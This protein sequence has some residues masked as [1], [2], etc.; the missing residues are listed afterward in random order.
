M[1]IQPEWV[2][3]RLE[4]RP[5]ALLITGPAGSGKSTLGAG[6]AVRTG[7]ALVDEDVLTNPLVAVVAELAGG[8]DDIDHAR[9]RERVR[10]ARYRALFD[11]VAAQL[12]CGLSV[13]AVAPFTAE[14]SERV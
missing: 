1:P 3:R 14:T 2:G 5:R 11:V 9:L 7:A 8:S 13:V 12:A 6:L 4:P 10:T